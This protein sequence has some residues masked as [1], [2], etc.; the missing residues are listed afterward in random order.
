VAGGG[1]KEE[2][3]EENRGAHGT[4]ITWWDVAPN[5]AGNAFPKTLTGGPEWPKVLTPAWR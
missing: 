1:E 5:E 3:D 2:D 4:A